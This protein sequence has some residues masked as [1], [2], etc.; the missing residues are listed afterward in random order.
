MLAVIFCF[1]I[2]LLLFVS[3]IVDDDQNYSKKLNVIAHISW[4]GNSFAFTI[5]VS[6]NNKQ[7]STAAK[8]AAALNLCVMCAL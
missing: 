7:N 2:I 1:Y 8:A 4:C 6:I 3:Y 5:T